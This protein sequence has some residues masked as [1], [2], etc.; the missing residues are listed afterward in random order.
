MRIIFVVLL[1]S[2]CA[3]EVG[4]NS[5]YNVITGKKL[6]CKKIMSNVCVEGVSNKNELFRVVDAVSIY[7]EKGE[8]IYSVQHDKNNKSYKIISGVFSYDVKDKNGYGVEVVYVLSSGQKEYTL[9][10]RDA[11]LWEPE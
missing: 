10:S 5:L 6:L 1:L 4:M 7:M 11:I 3:S 9:E 8:I 2:A